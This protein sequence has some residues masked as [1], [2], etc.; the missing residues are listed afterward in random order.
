MTQINLDLSALTLSEATT[1]GFA[2]DTAA[3]ANNSF[4]QHLARA[5]SESSPAEEA[6]TPVNDAAGNRHPSPAERATKQPETESAP[7]NEPQASEPQP[8][9]APQPIEGTAGQESVS[10]A[11]SAAS[12][13]TAQSEARASNQDVEVDDPLDAETD[14][15]D[16][17]ML[18]VVAALLAPPIV[19]TSSAEQPLPAA[20]AE[21]ALTVQ[22]GTSGQLPAVTYDSSLTTSLPP[23]TLMPETPP[24]TPVVTPPG[25]QASTA[26]AE[27]MAT[28]E[29]TPVV[30]VPPTTPVEASATTVEQ[31]IAIG[32]GLEQKAEAPPPS[33][34]G[35]PANQ[36]ETPATAADT[37]P[38]TAAPELVVE[39]TETPEVNRAAAD[40]TAVGPADAEVTTSDPVTT[41]AAAPARDGQ[42][43]EASATPPAEPAARKQASHASKTEE[44]AATEPAQQVSPVT[45]SNEFAAQ[46]RVVLS[47]EEENIDDQTAITTADAASSVAAAAADPNTPPAD[48]VARA[49]A[50]GNAAEAAGASDTPTTAGT[51]DAEAAEQGRQVDRVRFAQRVSRAFEAL[52]DRGGSLRL[53][54]S[55]PELGN[56]RLEVT[57]QQG[58]M[59]ARL[60][61]ETPAARNLL[62]ESLPGLRDRLAQQDIRVERFDVEL[63]DRRSG[64]GAE[65]FAGQSDSGRQSPERSTTRRGSSDTSTAAAASRP[66]SVSGDNHH[67]NIVI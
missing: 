8:E 31:S 9:P 56:L 12:S 64:G 35:R 51:A 16:F 36:D 65:Q 49:S 23:Q 59:T 4:N 26:V 67:L 40:V 34:V 39:N 5:Q 18:D 38:P 44:S 19:F 66:S 20:A 55:P 41:A 10:A 32:A 43:K 11:E 27:T 54:L 14:G 17:T 6:T 1:S 47:R 13:S 29:M 3:D 57:V 15:A 21:S 53:R 30:Q 48:A 28:V 63:M 7:R 24:V 45:I 46:T 37:A 61:T 50:S 2:N 60:E 62:L 22:I 33:P 25:P 58:V 42:S 52:G